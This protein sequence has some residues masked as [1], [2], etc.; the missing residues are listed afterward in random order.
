MKLVPCLT[1][2]RS[3]YFY[4]PISFTKYRGADKPLAG[5]TEINNGKVAI[6]HPTRGSLLPRRP[7]WKENFLIFFF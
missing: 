5:P 2:Q 3:F 4:L 6:F 1:E 7:R